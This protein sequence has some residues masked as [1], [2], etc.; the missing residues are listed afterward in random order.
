MG[1][2][3]IIVDEEKRDRFTCPFCSEVF[4]KPHQ[5][6]CGDRYCEGCITKF[7]ASTTEK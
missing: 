5:V 7:I 3:V 2:R 6:E 4:D 1:V